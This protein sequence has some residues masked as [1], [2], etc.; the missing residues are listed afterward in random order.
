[1]NGKRL[2]NRIV[3]ECERMGAEDVQ[4]LD[5]RKRTALFDF[6]IV[7]SVDN[8]VLAGAILARLDKVL[9]AGSQNPVRHEAPADARWIASDY[10]D[11]LFHLF[12][13]GDIRSHYDLESLWSSRAPD[14][15][16]GM[17]P[18]TALGRPL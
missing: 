10:G 5:V 4:L 12:V 16:R 7:V 14:R 11:T 2:A 13:G 8:S 9:A 17:V 15:D 6:I 18:G 1:M 3:I